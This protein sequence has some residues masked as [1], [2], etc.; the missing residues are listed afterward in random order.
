MKK[1][2]ILFGLCLC[3]GFSATAQD[4][5]NTDNVPVNKRGIA[6]LP[7]AGDHVIGVSADPFLVYL[8][9]FFGKTTTNASPEFK[10]DDVTFYG[11][12]FLEDNRAIRAKLRVGYS[13]DQ[14][15]YFITN[16]H[17][18]ANDPLNP[19]A[20]TADVVK[21]GTQGLGLSAGY[22]FRLGRGRL[23][24]FYGAEVSLGYDKEN[25]TYT[26]G[27]PMTD[28]NQ[29]P[30]TFDDTTNPPTEAH[31]SSR[32]TETKGG[33]AVNAGL[34][35]F[36]GVE[37]FFAPKISIG[38]EFG[39][40]LSFSSKAQDET[41]LEKFNASSGQVETSTSRKGTTAGSDL[42]FGTTAVG[43]LFLLFHF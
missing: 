31:K 14:T 17:I 9:N 28:V 23:Q 18:S 43:S 13:S 22:E 8:G 40:G 35:G 5:E 26:Y 30:T 15:K 1:I 2:I 33:L 4:G 42:S 27:N 6:I 16:D 21:T 37:Y 32:A 24:G 10:W 29:A 20:T 19:D 41:T 34:G 39:L 12:Y 38:G 3:A 25:I 11:K 7:K 36:I